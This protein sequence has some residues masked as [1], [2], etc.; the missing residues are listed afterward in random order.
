L[1][2]GGLAGTYSAEY[3]PG[4]ARK[5]LMN[6]GCAAREGALRITSRMIGR[7]LPAHFF[8]PR[9]FLVLN[10]RLICF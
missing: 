3:N 8:L 9:H 4:F 10:A 7:I 5:L 1:T 6:V 2:A